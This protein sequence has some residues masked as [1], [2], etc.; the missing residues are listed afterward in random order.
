M[1]FLTYTSL[2]YTLNLFNQLASSPSG[3]FAEP[4]VCFKTVTVELFYVNAAWL[5][6][7]TGHCFTEAYLCTLQTRKAPMENYGMFCLSG[8]T[9]KKIIAGYHLNTI[10]SY[11]KWQFAS[12]ALVF[13][14]FFKS[15]PYLVNNKVCLLCNSVLYE[16]FPMS[17][18]MEQ[19]GGQAFTGKQRVGANRSHTNCTCFCFGYS[20]SLQSFYEL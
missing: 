19:A 10:T 17:Y 13:D 3:S 5:L 18:L 16:V 6:M 12:F 20:I 2:A 15:M 7:F 14:V 4:L 1:S 9:D 8:S 11:D